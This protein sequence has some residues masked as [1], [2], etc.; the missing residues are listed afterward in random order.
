MSTWT[1]RVSPWMLSWLSLNRE[2]LITP[3]TLLVENYPSQ[4]R[5]IPWLSAKHLRWYIYYKLFGTISWGGPFKFFTNH[6]TLRYLVNKP[7]LKGRIYRWHILFQDYT[8]EVIVKLGKLNVG[9]DQLSQ[10]ESGETRGSVV[11]KLLD[12]DMFWVEAI[13]NYFED[14]VVFLATWKCL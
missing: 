1:H 14:I 10:L 13:P 2:I 6:S 11:D 4:K 5:I 8:F 3:F 12:V 7:V 9:P